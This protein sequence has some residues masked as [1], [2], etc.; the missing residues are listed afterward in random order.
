MNPIS[1]LVRMKC[2]NNCW[3]HNGKFEIDYVRKDSE[4]FCSYVADNGKPEKLKV[5]NC[6][7]WQYLYNKQGKY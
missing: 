4:S 2:V 3:F 5:L 7:V 6:Y 1:S